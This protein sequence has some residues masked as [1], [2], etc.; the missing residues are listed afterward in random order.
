MTVGKGWL[1]PAGSLS[2]C[3]ELGG[4]NRCEGAKVQTKVDSDGGGAEVLIEVDDAC[5]VS[6]SQFSPHLSQTGNLSSFWCTILDLQVSS[7]FQSCIYSIAGWT[8]SSEQL[9]VIWS[10]H[11]ILV[12]KSWHQLFS[13]RYLSVFLFKSYSTST[14]NYLSPNISSS[15]SS[16]SS[17]VQFNKVN[18]KG[19]PFNCSAFFPFLGT[20]VPNDT[21]NRSFWLSLLQ[22]PTFVPSW[23]IDLAVAKVPVLTMFGWM[24]GLDNIDAV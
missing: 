8:I 22:C 9:K 19:F 7:Q 11:A 17:L 2:H 14:H 16:L 6:K 20:F 1:I 15:S 24:I 12:F 3:S 13:D 23:I 18:S 21:L 10:N 5:R 4:E